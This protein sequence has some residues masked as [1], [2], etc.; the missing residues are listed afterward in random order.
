MGHFSFRGCSFQRLFTDMNY[1][2]V[3]VDYSVLNLLY[4]CILLRDNQSSCSGLDFSRLNYIIRIYVVREL[5]FLTTNASYSR[6]LYSE[7][8]AERKI[9]RFE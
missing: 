3:D 4:E 6:A 1:H 2:N 8:K 5:N 9:N 7:Y